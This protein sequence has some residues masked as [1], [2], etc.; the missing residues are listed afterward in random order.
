M[1]T[2]KEASAISTANYLTYV[3]ELIKSAANKGLTY[4]LILN[5]N[6]SDGECVDL[7]EKGFNVERQKSS[8]LIR[9]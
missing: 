2:A 5:E 3:T 4:T 7:I 1:L 6:I 9:W 8:C